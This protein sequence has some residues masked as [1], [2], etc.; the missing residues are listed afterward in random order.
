MSKHIE[1]SSSSGE[2][3]L[4]VNSAT[5]AG[6]LIESQVSVGHMQSTSL[7][8]ALDG[9]DDIDE[10]DPGSAELTVA[11]GTNIGSAVS[12]LDLSDPELHSVQL[13]RSDSIVHYAVQMTST[14][15]SNHTSSQISYQEL[16]EDCDTWLNQN[17]QLSDTCTSQKLNDQLVLDQR[18][19][20]LKVDQSTQASN[21]QLE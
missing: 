13:D 11:T 1:V 9:P 5:K 19:A 21:H 8:V 3:S 7:P 10:V 4:P 2:V 20:L 6:L 12:V 14:P 15:V 16:I 18:G 17:S